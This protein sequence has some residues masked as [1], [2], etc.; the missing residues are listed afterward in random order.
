[1]EHQQHMLVVA[2]QEALQLKLYRVGQAEVEM[3]MQTLRQV[4]AVLVL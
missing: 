4:K 1:M 3:E 2:A